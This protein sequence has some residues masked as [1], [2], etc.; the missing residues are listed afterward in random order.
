M[1]YDG[2]NRANLQ[3]LKRLLRRGFIVVFTAALMPP[4]AAQMPPHFSSNLSCFIWCTIAVIWHYEPTYIKNKVRLQGNEYK[5][6]KTYN[7]SLA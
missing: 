4:S 6:I 7:F 2:T 5:K 1:T 3:S